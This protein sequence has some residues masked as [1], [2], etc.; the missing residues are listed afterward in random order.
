[1]KGS[2]ILAAAAA[3]GVSASNAHRHAHGLFKRT[4]NATEICLP[5]CT[6]IYKTIYGEPT[7]IPNP[8]S[9]KPTSEAP[10]PPPPKPTS[11]YVPALQVPTPVAEICETPGTYTF[12]ATTITINETTTV[13]APA[14]TTLPVG[15]QTYGGVT[16]IVANSTTV[17]CPYATEKTTDG[18]VTS[19][20]ETTTTV[21]P[22][23][24][25]YTIAPTVTVCEKE[26]EVVYPTISTVTPGTYTRDAVTTTITEEHVVVVCPWTSEAPKPTP[27]PTPVYEAPKPEAPK[28]EA[29]KPEA[30]KPEAPKPEAPK[31]EAPKPEITKA[32]EPESKPTPAY[33]VPETPTETPKK[34][35]PAKETPKIGGAAGDH[36]AI[37]YTPFSQDASGSCKTAEQVNKDIAVIKQSGFDTIR[38]YSTD[39]STLENVGDACKEH[40]LR[41]IIGIFVKDTCN[42]ENPQ[43]KEQIDA[44]IK[45]GQA[46][47]WDLV[48]LFVI[49]NECIFQGRCDAASLK[50]L[51]VSVKQSCT[52]AG[53]KGPYTTAETLS[54]W[55]Q[56]EVAAIICPVVDV[57]GGQI[58]P[59]FNAEVAPA[60][61]GKFV[62]NQLDI[63]ENSIC[64]NKPALNLECGW[65]TG[66]SANGKATTGRAEQTLAITSIRELVGEKTV[67]FSFHDDEWKDPGACGCEQSWGCGHL[68]AGGNTPSY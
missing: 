33:E 24:G 3:A 47:H 52:A 60:D 35:T 19:V 66:G 68:F 2:L 8:P 30:P 38:V 53:Y 7:L 31:P 6:T 42:P 49:G 58:H 21:C 43:V 4:N 28:P 41:M 39:C 22:G 25:T 11:T 16:T 29:P 15:L 51:I 34:E 61:A 9:P 48:D 67:F 45:W 50:T 14:T 59:Y 5:G 18:V 63:L 12:P 62:K 54:V 37:T 40:G 46:G 26:Q 65:P 55:E 17:V 36:W 32:A 27:T 64:G 10:P 20:I 56:K 1:M 13:C 44:I 57:V 23:P